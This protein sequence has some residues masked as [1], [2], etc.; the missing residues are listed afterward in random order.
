MH[1]RI[2]VLIADDHPLIRDGLR[3]LL[4][5]QAD[6]E[7]VGE[8]TNGI[9]AVEMAR[10]LRPDVLLV[11]IAMPSMSGL[12]VVSLVRDSVPHTQI[13]ILSMYAKEAYTH[14]VL[15]EGARAYVL[16][17]APSTEVLAAIRAVHAGRYYF[18]EQVHTDVI[19]SYRGK[20]RQPSSSSNLYNSLTDRERQVFLLL[21]EGHSSQRIGDL[22]AISIKT[23]EKHRASISKKLGISQPVEMV[24][25]AIRYGIID[26]DFWKT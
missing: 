17:G 14:Q 1:E 22:L 7:M 26:P 20:E 4:H 5:L 23:V 16:K 12:E 10:A 13:V 11:D 24:K 25:F 19:N 2:R 21:I 3:Q 15:T 18:S 9:E 6:I 8:A